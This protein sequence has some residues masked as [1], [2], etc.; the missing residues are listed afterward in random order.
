MPSLRAKR[1]NHVTR[2]YW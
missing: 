1:G 2:A